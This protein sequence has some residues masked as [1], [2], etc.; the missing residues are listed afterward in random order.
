MIVTCPDCHSKAKLRDELAG[1]TVRCPKCSAEFMAAQ[2]AQQ[3]KWYYAS[4][5]EKIGPMSQKQFDE[6]VNDG[7]IGRETLVWRKGMS[8]WQ[9]LDQAGPVVEA[10]NKW[11]YAAGN[12]KLGPLAQQQFDRAVA[13][14]VISADT[15]VWRKGMSDWQPLSEIQAGKVASKVKAG[16]RLKYAGWG[17]RIVAKVIDLI[18]MLAL[19][20][21]VEGL[22]RKL[23]P[24]AY[25]TPDTFNPVFVVTMA[26]NMLLGIFYITWFVGRFGATPGKMAVKLKIVNPAGGKIGYGQAFG[27]YCGEFIVV[28]LTVMLGYLFGLFDSQKRT[29][30]DR[31][32]NT[33]VIAV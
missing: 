6:L 12:E 3:Q 29:L 22:S 21:M 4:G 27:R 32:C 13:D 10:R 30:H 20:L 17:G 14:G 5:S 18:F 8:D 25:A 15:L 28:F 23:F 7:T 11:Y 19:A 33:R 16:S 26:V 9:S 24:E 1:K 31:L 2:T